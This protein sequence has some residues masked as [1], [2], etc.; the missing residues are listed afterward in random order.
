MSLF[1]F[2]DMQPLASVVDVTE[3]AKALR[4]SVLSTLIARR[5]SLFLCGKSLDDKSSLRRRIVEEF[6]KD[7]LLRWRYSFVLPED[8]FEELLTGP[9]H[10]DLLTLENLLAD[11]VDAIVIIP[12]SWGAVTELGAF[13]NHDQ[14]RKKIVCVQEESKRRVKSFINY[15]PIRLLN[16]RHEGQV[17]YIDP[18]NLGEA[19]KQ[20]TKAV[21]EIAKRGSKNKKLNAI[22][23]DQF[24]LAA[25][26]LL[27]PID[28]STLGTLL[29]KTGDFDGDMAYS[30]VTA[31]TTV[32][33]KRG[34][35]ERT[36]YSWCFDERN[37][38]LPPS[39]VKL[40]PRGI[41]EVEQGITSRTRPM[42]RSDLDK[43]RT[44]AMHWQFKRRSSRSSIT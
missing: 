22:N 35:I 17:V 29:Q 43:L 18:D 6:D 44:Y 28:T 34:L 41:H 38:H 24:V 39:G 9:V 20:I 12:E 10:R 40:T 13:A 25:V 31:G 3:F 37:G 36:P 5:K 15:G 30:M 8:L 33:R 23:I 1:Q 14:L 26:Y 11:S 27:E 21:D 16:D 19:V 4:N 32:L 2:F 7:F 42:D